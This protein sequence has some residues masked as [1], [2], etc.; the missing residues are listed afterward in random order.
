MSKFGKKLTKIIDVLMEGDSPESD[1]KV[2][3][4]NEKG[5]DMMCMS[6]VGVDGDDMAV[7]GS[8][9]GAWESTM[10]V[11]AEDVVR[12]MGLIL[13]PATLAY[14]CKLPLILYKHRKEDAGEE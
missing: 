5:G 11:S 1:G 7:V 13:K 12:M 4:I 14:V 3:I 10:Y 8:L 6:S 9:M 2:H